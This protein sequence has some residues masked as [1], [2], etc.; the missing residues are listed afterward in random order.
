V[1]EFYAYWQV[2]SAFLNYVLADA[3]LTSSVGKIVVL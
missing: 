1:F 2:V 3:E